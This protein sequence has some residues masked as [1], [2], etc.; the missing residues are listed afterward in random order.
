MSLSP[1]QLAQDQ[2]F[3]QEAV[4]AS[5]RLPTKDD[6]S[7]RILSVTSE[8]LQFYYYNGTT[9]TQ[10]AGQ[11]AGT[12]VVGKLKYDHILSALGDTIGSF[13]D[14]S[15]SVT[16]TAFTALRQYKAIIAEQDEFTSNQKSAMGKTKAQDLTSGLGRG[17]YVFD[18]ETGMFYGIKADTSTTA[19]VSYK[20]RGVPNFVLS[21]GSMAEESSTSNYIVRYDDAGSSVTY[22]GKASPGTAT[23]AASWQISKLDESSSPDFTLLYADGNANFDN[24]WDNRASLSYS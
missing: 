19:T 20:V 4:S 18:H 9:L 21:G 7:G 2:N 15:A 22:I 1:L 8:T 6:A 3:G 14:S 24:I 10:D 5:R 17:E 11:A 16:S 13:G 23:S 12:L